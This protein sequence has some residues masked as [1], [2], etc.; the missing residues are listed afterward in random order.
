VGLVVVVTGQKGPIATLQAVRWV[1]NVVVK[2]QEPK[3]KTFS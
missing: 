1:G 3:R 2:M